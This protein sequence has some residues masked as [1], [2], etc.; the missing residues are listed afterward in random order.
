ML[1]LKCVTDSSIVL[2]PRVSPE[3]LSD[4]G[5]KASHFVRRRKDQSYV[6]NAWDFAPG[7]I[8]LYEGT[9]ASGSLISKFQ[10]KVDQGSNAEW[11]H[12]SIYTG[13]GQIWESRY[14]G[15]VENRG[16]NTSTYER[17]IAM[18]RYT[19]NIEDFEHKLDDA[20]IE[21]VGAPYGHKALRSLIKGLGRRLFGSS[22]SRN[23]SDPTL[24]TTITNAAICSQLVKRL[25]FQVLGVNLMPGK[26]MLPKDFADSSDFSDIELKWYHYDSN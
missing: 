26:T 6:L 23:L 8:I 18:R 21:E 7:D 1:P 24:D 14:P 3:N 17:T 5:L 9:G 20:L 4:H 15:G 12:V 22:V 19:G 13:D 16:F 2:P 11:S 10:Q 25:Y